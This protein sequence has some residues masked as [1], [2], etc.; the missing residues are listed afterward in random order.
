MPGLAV[1]VAVVAGLGLFVREPLLAAASDFV[2]TA[3]LPGI[4]LCCFVLD[5][6]PGVGAQPI[7]FLAYAGGIGVL[8]LFVLGGSSGVCA[9]VLGWAVGR[10]LRRWDSPRRWLHRSGLGPMLVRHRWRAVF[11]AAILPFPYVLTTIAAGT[12][13]V[14]L[15]QT[16]AGALGRYVKAALNLVLVAGGWSLGQ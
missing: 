9:G 6:I 14:S 7:L 2:A 1:L 4:F 10:A 15:A 13:G 3:G 8:P 16:V 12:A 11:T 5:S